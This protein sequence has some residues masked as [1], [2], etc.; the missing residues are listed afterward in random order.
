M[1]KVPAKALEILEGGSAGKLCNHLMLACNCCK[2][3]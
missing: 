2:C 3:C 1:A